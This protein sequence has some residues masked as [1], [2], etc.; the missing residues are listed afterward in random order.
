MLS[1]LVHGPARGGGAAGQ[2]SLPPFLKVFPQRGLPPA[3]ERHCAGPIRALLVANSYISY[4]LTCEVTLEINDQ[5][6]FSTATLNPLSHAGDPEPTPCSSGSGTHKRLLH[7]MQP[8]LG[9]QVTPKPPQMKQ[10]KARVLEKYERCVEKWCCFFAPS[11]SSKGVAEGR[12]LCRCCTQQ[13]SKT[14]GLST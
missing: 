8:M 5:L 12:A 4:L 13:L 3:T 11:L 2:F 6:G 10:L 9:L 1:A 14:L 7:G